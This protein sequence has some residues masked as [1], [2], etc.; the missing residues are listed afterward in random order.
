MT[1]ES[2]CSSAAVGDEP[3]PSPELIEDFAYGRLP[4]QEIERLGRHTEHC[5]RCRTSLSQFE[6]LGDT[7]TREARRSLFLAH[8]KE[9]FSHLLTKMDARFG[10]GLAE[11]WSEIRVAPQDEIDLDL[12]PIEVP[13]R[14]G[15]Y[16]VLEMIGRGGMGVVYRARHVALKSQR[17][18]KILHPGRMGK[19][20]QIEQF[21]REIE[22]VGRLEHPNIVAAHDALQ[23]AGYH[24]L[25]MEHVEG[26]NVARLVRQLGRIPVADACEICRQAA[27]GLGYAHKHGMI[28][29]DVKPSNLLLSTAG[30]VKVLDLGLVAFR[31]A[32]GASPAKA[33][34][35]LGTADYMAPEQWAGEQEIDGRADVYS[36]GC[37]LYQLLVGELPE[38]Q[39][40]RSDRCPQ[41]PRALRHEVPKDVSALVQRMLSKRP[42]DR[43]RRADEV[44]A[45][46]QPH[47]RGNDL[48]RLAA[49]AT[50]RDDDTLDMAELPTERQTPSPR[51]RWTR[52]GLLVAGMALLGGSGA[53]GAF[54]RRREPRSYDLPIGGAAKWL[55]KDPANTVPPPQYQAGKL[56]LQAT[57]WALLNLGAATR[58][59]YQLR[60]TIT[61]ASGTQH[62]GLFFGFEPSQSDSSGAECQLLDFEA[63]KPGTFRLNW[64]EFTDGSIY[65]LPLPS[66]YPLLPGGEARLANRP[67]EL[68]VTV[69]PQG[70]ASLTVDGQAVPTFNWSRARIQGGH[71]RGL[72]RVG[73]FVQAGELTV[74]QT[75]IVYP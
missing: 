40:G 66:V 26:T 75:Q 13:K 25:V 54:W 11:A 55:I 16:E 59:P 12:L 74:G 53:L 31:K 19:P 38:S 30:I 56:V 37:T 43:P 60:T 29:R 62:A 73:L 35:V 71:G 6:V 45:A 49:Q 7:F 3:C 47:C 21:Y 48:R 27:A 28:H 18:L 41:D 67:Y 33:K 63:R 36:L 70:V 51:K 10:F 69:E 72:G 58:F 9:D 20:G 32:N 2:V 46:L 39:V 23:D 68:S 42:E 57:G 5:A 24:F 14:L 65:E 52:R 34:E 8:G 15:Q 1:V 64:S 4:I 61:V 17:A 44:C 22:A 50:G